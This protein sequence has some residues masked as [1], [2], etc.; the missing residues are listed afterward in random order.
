MTIHGTYAGGNRMLV[1]TTY[2]APLRAIAD[3]LSLTPAL[4]TT[5][6]YDQPFLNFLTRH[7]RAGHRVVDVGANIGLFTVRMGQLVG[8]TGELVSWRT[9]LSACSISRSSPS[10]RPTGTGCARASTR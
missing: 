1:H 9:A 8:P 5:G 10:W 2:G 7:V 6:T 4:V 3:D